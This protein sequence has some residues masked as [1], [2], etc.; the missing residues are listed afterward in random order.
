MDDKDLKITRKQV[1]QEI[2]H[3]ILY[4][5]IIILLTYLL[6]HFVGQRTCVN[7]SSMEPSLSNGDNLIVDKISYRLHDP[8]RFDIIV[9]PFRYEEKKYYIKR[10]IGLP[11]EKIRIDDAGYIYINDKVLKE[12]YGLAVMESPGIAQ[13]EITLGKDEYF[14]L[15]DNRNNSTDSRSPEV[16][17]VKRDIIIGRAWLKIYPFHKIGFVKHQ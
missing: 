14:V 3:L 13:D 17:V 9:F 15:G 8:E 1:V 10:I 2:I 16:G 12:S 5:G 4:I 7:G 6:L 11:G